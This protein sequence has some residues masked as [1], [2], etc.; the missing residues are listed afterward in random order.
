MFFWFCTI[1][2]LLDVIVYGSPDDPKKKNRGFAFLDYAN[3]KMASAALRQMTRARLH[4][5]GLEII[6]NWAQ[7]QEE[8]NEETMSK[9][10][11]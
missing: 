8:P 3:H 7:P 2:G 5:W 6:L 4:I 1:E 11:T 10:I 9:V